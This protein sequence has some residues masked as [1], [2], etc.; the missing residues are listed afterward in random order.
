M[1]FDHK[2]VET[3]PNCSH[4]L[5]T[6]LKYHMPLRG[7]SLVRDRKIGIFLKFLLYIKTNAHDFILLLERMDF[8]E[9]KNI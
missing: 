6:F 5:S 8:I 9:N 4:E 1:Y 7:H 2:H 3:G